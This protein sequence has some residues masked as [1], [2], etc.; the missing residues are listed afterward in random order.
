MVDI[1]ELKISFQVKNLINKIQ[2]EITRS[3]L[4]K[5]LSIVNKKY[6]LLNYLK[7][8]LELDLIEMTNPLKPN[9][10]NQKYKLKVKIID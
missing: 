1:N 7:P 3:D 2:G 5:E 4:Q 6:F 9:R 8:A 10:K